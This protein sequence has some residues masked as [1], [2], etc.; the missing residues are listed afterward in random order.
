VTVMTVVTVV[1]VVKVAPVI[2]IAVLSMVIVV[3]GDSG[4]DMISLN[5][6]HRSFSEILEFQLFLWSDPKQ[7]VRKSDCSSLGGKHKNFSILN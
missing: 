3:S 5:T 4:T 1:K 6:G 2:V 7:S